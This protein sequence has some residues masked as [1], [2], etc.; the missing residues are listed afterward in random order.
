MKV[1]IK[2]N[3]L[4]NYAGRGWSSLLTLLFVPFYIKFL[5]VESYGLVG[6]YAT[7]QA[8]FSLLDLGFSTT[9]NRELAILSSDN[10][11]RQETGNT[12]RTLESIYWCFACLIFLLTTLLAPLIAYHWINPESLS[13]AAV[14]E[15]IQLM[16]LVVSLRFPFALYSGGL[17]G[18]QRQVLLNGIM[19]GSG[20][21]R[22]GGAVL[23]LWLVSPTIQ[24]FFVFQAATALLET[25]VVMF[26]LWKSIPVSFFSSQFKIGVLKK[27]YRFAAGMTGIGISS[28]MLTQVDKIILSKFVSLEV[29]GYYSLAATAST[30]LVS[31][32]VHPVFNAV[33]PRLSQ[34]VKSGTAEMMVSFYHKSCQMVSLLIIPAG[35]VVVFFAQDVLEIWTSNFFVA[36]NAS[37]LL[38]VM[39]I[40]CI[41][42][43]FM[44]IPYALQLANGWTSLM[45][46]YNTIAVIVAIPVLIVITPSYGAIG[47]S[48]VWAILNVSYVFLVPPIMHRRLLKSEKMKWYVKDIGFPLLCGAFSVAALSKIFGMLEF[49]DLSKIVLTMMITAAVVAISSEQIRPLLLRKRTFFY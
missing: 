46:K 40:G 34:L 31:L 10:A 17:M 16:G 45:F 47:A 26:F 48:M 14:S 22:G 43:S 19:V 35:L 13:Q 29:F 27:V 8:V 4:A 15:A 1:S 28:M 39:T 9:L 44:N 21:L 2:L 18:L 32:L 3:I 41:F 38:S 24:A 49:G 36:A 7:I 42:N 6:F 5:G 23:V 25:T 33:F 37:N 30:G 11:N 20:S 12:V